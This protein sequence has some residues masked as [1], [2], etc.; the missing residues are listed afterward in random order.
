MTEVAG[1]YALMN[2]S[3]MILF[4]QRITSVFEMAV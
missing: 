2:Q 4:R 3:I 1:G